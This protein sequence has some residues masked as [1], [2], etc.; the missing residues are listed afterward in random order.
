M[1]GIYTQVDGKV[2]DP[3]VFPSHT[4]C[5]ILYLLHD[6]EEIHELLT[7]CMKKLPVLCRPINQLK[8][9][10]P[11]CH[12]TRTTGQEI[13]GNF[14]SKFQKFIDISKIYRPTKFSSTEDFPADCPPTTAICGRSMLLETPSCVK[15][16]CILFMMGMRFSM[17]WFPGM[18]TVMFLLWDDEETRGYCKHVTAGCSNNLSLL[19]NIT[20]DSLEQACDVIT[21]PASNNNTASYGGD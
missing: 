13:S 3:L 9:K 16:S 10:W 4:I 7:F 19:I 17:P 18:M 2:A 5:L 14:N 15:T 6:G 8:N 11:S 1:R 20:A 21:T 12:N